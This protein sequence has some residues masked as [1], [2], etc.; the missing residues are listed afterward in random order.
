MKK[1]IVVLSGAGLDAESG[2][3]T[4]RKAPATSGISRV[5]NIL[6]EGNFNVNKETKT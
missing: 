4:F 5:L 2:I 1:K 6:A 3:A